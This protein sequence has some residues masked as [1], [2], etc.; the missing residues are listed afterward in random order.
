MEIF[1]DIDVVQTTIIQ[2]C[3]YS[4]ARVLSSISAKGSDD[5]QT[6]WSEQGQREREAN[7]L[8][9]APGIDRRNKMYLTNYIVSGSNFESC[10]FHI[11]AGELG[12]D[13]GEPG[14]DHLDGEHRQWRLQDRVV[15]A[16]AD[17]ETTS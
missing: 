3:F 1:L 7:S 11:L 15:R 4:P 14:G 8:D 16:R 13:V 12:E 5:R 9:V 6:E 2:S 10:S 17:Q